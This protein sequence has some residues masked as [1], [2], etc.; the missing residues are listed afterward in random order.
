LSARSGDQVSSDDWLEV[1]RTEREYFEARMRFFRSA[2]DPVGILRDALS[3]P[4]ERGTALR[5]LAGM[6]ERTI[7]ALLPDLVLLASHVNRDLYAARGIIQRFERS[8]LR[9]ELPRILDDI[10]EDASDE[11]YRRLAELL[12]GM[13]EPDLLSRLTIRARTTDDPAI[14]EVADDFDPQ[15]ST[16]D[17]SR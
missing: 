6:D 8:W 2:K 3:R 16:S 12:R 11:E 1:C 15:T 4:A 14:R 5:V 17:S 7:R 9:S 13:D 10:L